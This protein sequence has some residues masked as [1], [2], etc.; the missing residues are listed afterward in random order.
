MDREL[1]LAG[2]DRGVAGDMRCGRQ[3]LPHQVR[4]R[5]HFVDET[6]VAGLRRRKRLAGQ[7]QF[8]G[9]ALADRA[10]QGL[11]AATA[12][13]DA[14]R[15]FGQRKARGVGGVE[16]VASA[17]DLAAAAIG[18]AIDGADDRDRAID[19]RPHHP[20]EDDVLARPLLVGHAAAFLEV[21]A[22]TKG[23]VARSG[24]DDAA[25]IAGSS[26]M[27]SKQRTRSRPIWVLSA[28]EASGR[29]SRTIVTCS[30]AFS[31]ARVSNDSAAALISPRR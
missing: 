26:A 11:R 12:R 6:P 1:G 19:Q 24:Q 4:L 10:G 2:R 14:E 17:R 3:R 28:L 7:D 9:A 27:S 31:S 20:L 5:K 21:A 25:Q 29:F 30:S 18:R 16:E 13:H 15:D 23:L 22:R 8:L